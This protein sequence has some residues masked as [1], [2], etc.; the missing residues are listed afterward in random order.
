MTN[1]FYKGI[2]LSID[3]GFCPYSNTKRRFP[4]NDT[5]RKVASLCGLRLSYYVTA[6]LLTIA[7]LCLIPTAYRTA[8][9]LYIL[10]SLAVLPSVVKAM[11]F[12]NKTAKKK[13]H[14]LAYPLFCKKYHYDYF[15]YQSISVSYLLLFILFAAW[16]ISYLS[17]ADIPALLRNLP[18]LLGSSSLVIRI[19]AVLGYRLYFRFFPL[20]AMR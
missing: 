8:S 13:E 15:T 14:A 9:P 20:H 19:F 7:F 16:H 3:T 18:L 17:Q 12:S 2:I 4:M 6:A 5:F 11:F 1:S 10:L